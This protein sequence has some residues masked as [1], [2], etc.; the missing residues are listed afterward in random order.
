MA[1]RAEHKGIYIDP[2]TDFGFSL[3]F[4]E[5]VLL[6]DFL[7]EVLN[8][9]GCIKELTYAPT[10]RIGITKDDRR[11]IFDLYCTTGTGEHIIVEMQTVLHK[12]YKERT[13]YYISRL[14]QEQGKR[15]KDWDFT[16]LPVYLINIANFEIDKELEKKTFLSRIKLMYEEINQPYYNNF[17]IVY[18]EL[19]LFTKKVTELES[20]IDRW[21][22]TLKYLPMLERQ[23]AALRKDIFEKLFE[24]ARIARLPKRQ[25]NAYYKS[26]QNM[27]IIKHTITDYKST[28][29]TLQSTIT[30]LQT[31]NATLQTSNAA[32]DKR[33][34]AKDKRIAELERRLGIKRR[35]AK[36]AIP[37]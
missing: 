23:P 3:I 18:L 32:K 17:T 15:G 25:Q 8:I 35:S 16:L 34:A 14:I 27:S 6:I 5:K 19:P 10:I 26:L 31:S 30:T 9:K 28:I 13:I 11:A 29:T 4:G 7:N 22:Y 2:L 37:A 1:K 24:M 12:N 33:I 20:N 36:N 21:M